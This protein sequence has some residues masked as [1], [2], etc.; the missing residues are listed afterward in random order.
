MVTIVTSVASS[1]LPRDAGVAILMQAFQ[2][3]S[4]TAERIMGSAGKGFVPA[5][6][7]VPA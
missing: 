6:A 7:S 4:A 1:Q 3:D 5:V 2:L